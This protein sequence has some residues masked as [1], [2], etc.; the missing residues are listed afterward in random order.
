VRAPDPYFTP[1]A[2]RARARRNP[3]AA[4][5][6]EAAA[7]RLYRG[8]TGEG[9][10]RRRRVRVPGIPRALV[11]IGAITVIQYEALRDGQVNE[12]RHRFA[13]KARPRLLLSPDGLVFIALGGARFRFTVNGFVDRVK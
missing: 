4:G 8:F 6:P 13:K 1:P 9:P 7:E 3:I 5:S 12:Y 11:D 2:E 10:R